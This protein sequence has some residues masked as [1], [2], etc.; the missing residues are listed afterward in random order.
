MHAL[1]GAL[2]A[3]A[4]SHAA[5]TFPR[6]RQSMDRGL[7]IGQGGCNSSLAP[8]ATTK[9]TGSGNGQACYWFNNG[10]D[11]GC[12]TCDGTNSSTGHDDETYKKY[13]YKGKTKAQLAANNMTTS[14]LAGLWAPKPGDMTIDAKAYPTGGPSGGPAPYPLIKSNCGKR[15]KPTI[16]DPKLRTLN[17]DAECGSDADIYQL[18]PWRAPGTAPIMDSC[19]ACMLF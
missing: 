10:C 4:V 6:P 2:V 12:A 19:G 9:K 13:V 7:Q 3:S 5:V 16:C 8:S 18:S 17:V 14:T 11:F 1:L 15:G